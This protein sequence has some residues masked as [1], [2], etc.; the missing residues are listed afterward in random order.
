[1]GEPLVVVVCEVARRSE[2]EDRVCQLLGA[3]GLKLDHLKRFIRTSFPVV[4]GRGPRVDR[5]VREGALHHLPPG[6][7]AYPAADS[8]G[9]IRS[10]V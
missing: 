7:V 8:E 10:G 4:S 2:R 5:T 3:V 9:L 6:R 1:M